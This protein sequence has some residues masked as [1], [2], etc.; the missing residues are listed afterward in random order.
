MSKLPAITVFFWIMKICATTLGETAGDLL[1]MT[2]NVG[3]AVSSM[4]LIG[5]FL[6]TLVTQ[7]ISKS[8]NPL[9]YWT[10]ILSTST[11]GT[12]MSDYINTFA[13]IR[14]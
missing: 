12:T 9:L 6:T 8:Y 5:V 10:V 1:S 11:A 4:I 13:K 14:A 2:L 7:L 3:Y